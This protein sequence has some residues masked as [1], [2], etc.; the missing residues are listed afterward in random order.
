MSVEAYRIRP[1]GVADAPLVDGWRAQP[2]VRRWW[3]DP[4]KEPLADNLAD[5]KL[6]LWIVE[7]AGRSFAFIQ[8]YRVDEHAPHPFDHLPPGARGLD[9]FIGEPD[10]LGLGHG[11]RLLRQHVDAMFS[12][13]V[14]AAGVDPHPENLAARRAFEKAGFIATS[15]P[16]ET[17]WGRAVLMERR[18][19]P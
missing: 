12:R 14:P 4:D 10:M 18:A 15:G 16:L 13:G 7:L 5:P 17:R 2:H 11:P 8:D 19:P 9:L 6:A 1:C 3:G